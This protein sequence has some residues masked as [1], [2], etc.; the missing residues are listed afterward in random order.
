[1]NQ[2]KINIF[3]KEKELEETKT[4]LSEKENE[5]NETNLHLKEKEKE[6]LLYKKKEDEYKN[7]YWLK[8]KKKK[9]FQKN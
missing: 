8:I 1:M 5:L 3:N 9:K 4:L 2:N 7:I 6:I